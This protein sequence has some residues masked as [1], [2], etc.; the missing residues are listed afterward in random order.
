AT[1]YGR[2]LPDG[3]REIFP[4]VDARGMAAATGLTS[5]VGDMAKFV[6]AQFRRGP[7]GG[8]QIVGSGSLRELHRVRS[9]DETWVSGNGL[10]F[11]TQRI[12]DKSYIGHA[13]GYPGYTTQTLFQ[14]ADRF[15]VIV[16]TNTQDSEPG[17]IARQL[18]AAVGPVIAKAVPKPATVAWDPAWARFEGV[19]RNRSNDLAVVLLNDRLVL[20]PNTA[21]GI[22]AVGKLEPLGGGRF[23]LDAPTG[24][25]AIG[26]VVQFREDA[27]KPTRL[28]VGDTWSD[29]VRT[30]P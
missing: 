9:V 22:E 7:R 2:R 20:L 16:L 1:P 19:Y 14:P 11:G 21:P 18:I 24:G 30:A 23:R 3:T 8:A 12:K 27:G 6:S 25:T 17:E 26:E 10:G 5:D 4:F 28:Y 15:G 29:R 13:G